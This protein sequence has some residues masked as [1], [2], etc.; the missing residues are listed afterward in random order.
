MENRKKILVVD[1]REDNLRMYSLVIKS[2]F[3]G[4]SILTTTESVKT[5]E[6]AERE[7]P[8][9]ILLDAMMPEMDGWE[10]T[11][12]IRSDL[13]KD[14]QPYIIAMTAGAMAEDRRKCF[15]VGMDAFVPKPIRRAELVDVLKA[16]KEKRKYVPEGVGVE[17]G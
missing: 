17:S 16:A 12:R 10:A 6:I 13:P 14:R 7:R 9:L 2:Q 3:P 8:D 1:D 15:E 5:F 4:T 11:T